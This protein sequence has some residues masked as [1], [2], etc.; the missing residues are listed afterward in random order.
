MSVVGDVQPWLEAQ[1]LGAFSEV[2]AQG[3]SGGGW[4][5]GHH[6]LTSD[7]L[8]WSQKTEDDSGDQAAHH[9]EVMAAWLHPPRGAVDP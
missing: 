8:Q 4:V 7:R 6:R 1:P 2:T 9:N 5:M 3:F